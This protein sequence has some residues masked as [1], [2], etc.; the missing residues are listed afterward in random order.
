MNELL[1]EFGSEAIKSLT[2]S[3]TS[4]KI[5][6]EYISATYKEEIFKDIIEINFSLSFDECS[7]KYGTWGI[8]YWKR[9]I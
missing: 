5:A 6:R 4:S 8:I 1:D 3:T 9:V 7:D 2:L